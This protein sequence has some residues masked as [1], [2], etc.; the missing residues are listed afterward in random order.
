MPRS[1][2]SCPFSRLPTFLSLRSML[3]RTAGL[4]AGDMMVGL[5]VEEK[6]EEEEEEEEDE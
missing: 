1:P 6:E 5:A 4:S 3:V 2:A